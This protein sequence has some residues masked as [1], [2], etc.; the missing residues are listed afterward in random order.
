MLIIILYTLQIHN[1]I[2]VPQLL[3]L[4]CDKIKQSCKFNQLLTP[5]PPPQM[6]L[7]LELCE[8]LLF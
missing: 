1:Y 2:S 6:V 4:Q 7:S 5:P 3:S 8:W